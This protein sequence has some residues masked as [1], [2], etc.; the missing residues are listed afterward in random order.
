MRFEESDGTYR[1]NDTFLQRCGRGAL[2]FQ[3]PVHQT[4]RLRAIDGRFIDGELRATALKVT[5]EHRSPGG[6]KTLTSGANRVTRTC[7]RVHKTKTGR[8]ILQ[9]DA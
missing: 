3:Y 8:A 1:A 7:Q 6:S 5:T 2:S 9:E 4:F